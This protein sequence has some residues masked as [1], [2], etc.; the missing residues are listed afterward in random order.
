MTDF[1]GLSERVSVWNSREWTHFAL[2]GG[3]GDSEKIVGIVM[4][5]HFAVKHLLRWNESQYLSFSGSYSKPTL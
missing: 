5:L 1:K 4:K 2:L 3:L